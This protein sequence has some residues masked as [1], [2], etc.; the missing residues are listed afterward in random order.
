[1]LIKFYLSFLEEIIS[2]ETSEPTPFLSV[3]TKSDSSLMDVETSTPEIALDTSVLTLSTR[4]QETATPNQGE[5]KLIISEV[6]TLL[7]TEQSEPCKCIK[8]LII[9]VW[10]LVFGLIN[11]THLL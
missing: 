5:N 8:I 4:N 9:F 10:I 3:A 2:T 1:M 11:I 6:I 7:P